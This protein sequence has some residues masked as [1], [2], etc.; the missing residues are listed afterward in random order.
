MIRSKRVR[1]VALVA[2]A[3]VPLVTALRVPPILTIARLQYDGG[4]D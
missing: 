3:L 2:V 1:A 4:G